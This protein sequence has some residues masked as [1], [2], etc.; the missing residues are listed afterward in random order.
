VLPVA[1]VE[2]IVPASLVY[3]TLVLT[4]RIKLPMRLPKSARIKDHNYPDP[5][6]RRARMADGA[7]FLGHDV[8][9]HQE[10]W[11]TNEDGRQHGTIPGTT[12]VGKTTTITSFLT[13]AL[14]HNSGF[15][16]V[17]GKADNKLFGEILALARR[18][19]REDDVLALNFLVASGEKQSNT[20]NPFATGNSDAIRE[21]LVSQLGEQ[22]S[23][24]NNGVF[25]GRAVA[26]IGTIAPVLT[27][28]RDNRG[29]PINIE[30]I[31]FCLELRWIW[32]LATHRIFMVRNPKGGNPIE[33]DLTGDIPEDVIYPLQAYLGELPGYDSSVPWN[34]QK[35]NKPSEQHGYA[36]MYFTGTFTQLA[37][38]LG[39]IFKTYSGDIDMRDVVLNRRILVVNLPAL[40]NSD[41]TLAALGKIVVASLRGMMAQILGARLEGD[42]DA[43][44][45]NKP[46]MGVAPFHVVLDEL[47]YYATSGLDRML[48]MGRGLNIMFWLAFQE[49]SG[50]WARIGEKTASLLGNA[51]LTVAMRQQDAQRTRQWLQE[52]A[53]QT[54]VTQTA[55][56][57]TSEIGEYLESRHADLRQISRVDSQWPAKGNGPWQCL[58]GFPFARAKMGRPGAAPAGGR[59]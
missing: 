11:I 1:S 52:T 40:E 49:V 30:T 24:D 2:L 58:V 3:T 6:D 21:L 20:F 26:L 17:D 56:F 23:E 5:K 19:G 53:G 38:S 29:I 15:V 34:E 22:R 54:F 48:A 42:Y 50:I 57:Q 18:F 14:T 43:I 51:N 47:A 8:E 13:N 16:L 7:I 27:W 41:D 10:L 28:M 25:R 12:G 4:R 45:A 31:R 55:G 35:D 36:L 39:H 37:V 9:T 32:T 46:G 33:Y 59:H 44:V